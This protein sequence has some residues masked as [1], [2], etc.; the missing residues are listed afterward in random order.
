MCGAEQATCVCPACQVQRDDEEEIARIEQINQSLEPLNTPA[1]A[2]EDAGAFGPPSDVVVQGDETVA[3]NAVELSFSPPP[4]RHSP[5]SPSEDMSEWAAAV[6]RMSEVVNGKQGRRRLQ[7]ASQIDAAIQNAQDAQLVVARLENQV[8]TLTRYV[9]DSSR[10]SI[11]N[12]RLLRDLISSGQVQLTARQD[13]ILSTLQ[14]VIDRRNAAQELAERTF[15]RLDQLTALSEQQTASLREVQQVAETQ[16]QSI[17]DAQMRGALR[18]SQALELLGR[19][20]LQQE[21]NARTAQLANTIC[22]DRQRVVPFS[23]Q[24]YNSGDSARAR[25]RDIGLSNK[26]LAGMLLHT[27]R[28]ERTMCENDP[29]LSADSGC[30]GGSSTAPYGIDPVFKRGAELYEPDFDTPEEKEIYYNCS[31]IRGTPTFNVQTNTSV[32]T[33]ITNQPPFCAELFNLNDVPFGFSSLP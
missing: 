10:A 25:D 4:S 6:A 26:L 33:F 18:L 1:V 9:E 7:Q 13:Q 19:V 5:D 12:D 27:T 2:A 14:T 22:S 3:D 8:D 30:Y 15:E 21:V 32:A 28:R 17:Q 29:F 31:D 23:V 24:N 11:T 16:L 20:R